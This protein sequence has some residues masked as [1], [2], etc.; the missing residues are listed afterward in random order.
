[1]TREAVMARA[2]DNFD[3][4]VNFEDLVSEISIPT[5]S[6]NSLHLPDLYRYLID[7]MQIA[8]DAMGYECRSYD[9][10][11]EGKGTVQLDHRQE[12]GE[13]PIVFGCGHGDMVHGYDGLFSRRIEQ[14]VGKIFGS[15]TAGNKG[16]HCLHMAGVYG[17]IGD[18]M[19]PVLARG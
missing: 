11:T 6:Q 18:P 2:Q 16:Q 12:G 5:E 4:G 17:D 19:T 15:G 7:E 14:Q 3:G 1:M 10:P 9:N 13:L 8:F